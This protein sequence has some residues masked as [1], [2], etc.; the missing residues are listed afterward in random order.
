MDRIRI[1]GG[2]RLNG[3]IPISGAKNATLPLMIASL[4]TPETSDAA[5]RTAPGRCPDAAAHPA[6][7]M[8]STSGSTA[9]APARIG[10]GETIRPH[11]RDHRR[12]RRPPMSSCR[13]C[14]R[15][16]GCWGRSSPAAA[17]RTSR[18]PAAAPSA[19]ARSTCT[20]W[21]WS[22]SAPHIEHRSRLC[23]RG[24]AARGCA[25]T[26]SSSRKCRSAPP[27]RR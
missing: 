20:S 25:A 11:L 9:S 1:R 27:M 19:P 21:R 5:Q 15:A 4:L 17:R 7:I 6:A 16:S 23:H 10:R 2:N 13:G 12:H 8:A 3:T 24:G 22:S 18:C 14:G 26:A